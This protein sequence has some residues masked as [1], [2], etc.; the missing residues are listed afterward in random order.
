MS[1]VTW[2][3]CDLSVEMVV[4]RAQEALGSPYLVFPQVSRYAL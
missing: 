3:P 4:Q 2:V 1:V